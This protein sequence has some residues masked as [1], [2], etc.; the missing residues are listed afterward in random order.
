MD[1]EQFVGT[2]KL[3]AMEGRKSN[4]EIIYPYGE[5]PNGI[6][7][8][9]AG[10]WM[11]AQIFRIGRPGIASGDNGL[12]TVEEARAIVAGSVGYFGTYEVDEAAKTVMHTVVGSLI[13]NWENGVQR[14]LYEL[15][16]NRITLTTPSLPTGGQDSIHVLIWER[17]P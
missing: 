8:Y 9:T 5:H 1:K 11:S 12:T 17:I 10:G 16:G 6:V 4:G 3:I 15:S 2:W 14:R 13:P 7:T